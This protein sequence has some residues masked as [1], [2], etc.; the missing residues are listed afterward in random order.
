MT[1]F[2]SSFTV[3]KCERANIL[4]LRYAKY[5]LIVKSG[6]RPGRNKRESQMWTPLERWETHRGAGGQV[7][8]TTQSSWD[9]I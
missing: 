4:L 1:T 6:C 9:N 3:I 8:G 5:Y 2:L 7:S